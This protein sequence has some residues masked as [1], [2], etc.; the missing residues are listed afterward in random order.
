MAW[1]GG[2]MSKPL[3]TWYIWVLAEG[4]AQA[5]L[6]SIQQRRILTNVDIQ[7]NLQGNFSPAS[8]KGTVA[9]PLW[10]PFAPVLTILLEA[11]SSP[12]M[13]RPG[14]REIPPFPAELQQQLAVMRGDTMPERWIC[15]VRR[16]KINF[17]VGRI[18]QVGKVN[19]TS[20]FLYQKHGLI[21]KWDGAEAEHRFEGLI[22]MGTGTG[23][24]HK[25]W[26]M[27]FDGCSTLSQ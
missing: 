19:D 2:L 14:E 9:T 8:E 7:G 1:S 18:I 16:E 22:N 26:S 5:H 23:G 20:P 27:I 13:T 6:L 4:R 24:N 10:N 12:S 15:V 3:W 17:A 21:K 25:C 11:Q